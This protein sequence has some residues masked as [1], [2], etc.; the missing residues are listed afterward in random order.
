MQATIRT[1]C[2]LFRGL[3]PALL[4]A[5]P[6]LAIAQTAPMTPDI[7]ATPFVVPTGD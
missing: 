1:S 4:A 5:A 2:R 7:A 6:A 3:L